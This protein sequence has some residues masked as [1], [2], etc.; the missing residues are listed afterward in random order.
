MRMNLSW[1]LG[2]IDWRRLL[3]LQKWQVMACVRA[4][5]W[6]S[7]FLKCAHE[8]RQLSWEVVNLKAQLA[9]H[10]QE[11]PAEF[12]VLPTELVQKGGE[13]AM[14]QQSDRSEWLMCQTCQHQAADKH[15]VVDPAILRL[16]A[17]VALLSPLGSAC[18]QMLCFVWSELKSLLVAAQSFR[19]LPPS[20]HA[21]SLM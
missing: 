5:R 7:H 15:V 20:R 19:S 4:C 11:S 10:A 1:C 16:H 21:A 18:R 9:S 12:L 14:L 13:Q 8:K 17:S 6:R 3:L 2:L